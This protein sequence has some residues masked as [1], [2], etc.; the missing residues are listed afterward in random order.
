MWVI[1]S[2]MLF[3]TMRNFVSALERPGWIL[4]IS[5]AGIPLNALVSWALIFGILLG[6]VLFFCWL[7]LTILAAIRASEGVQY[8]YPLNLRLVK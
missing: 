3:Q 8:R 1:P 6:I 4:I 7:A 2:W 5:T